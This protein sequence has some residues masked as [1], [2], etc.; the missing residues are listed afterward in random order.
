MG[1]Y[2]RKIS[3]KTFDDPRT[4]EPTT[5]TVI[6]FCDFQQDARVA[7]LSLG[8]PVDAKYGNVFLHSESLEQAQAKYEVGA[9]YSDLL[10]WGDAV[11]NFD[12]LYKV[13][14]KSQ[15]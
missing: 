11:E 5:K 7:G 9:D 15:G 3:E 10:E 8:C 12:N 14:L 1:L 13:R 4:N 6:T 2:I